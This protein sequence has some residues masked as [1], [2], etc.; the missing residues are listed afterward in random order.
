MLHLTYW[1]AG[2]QFGP[3]VAQEDGW[4]NAGQVMRYFREKS[5]L[6]AKTFG[7]LYG[8]KIREDGKPICERWI[9]EMELENKVPID[10]TR[11][12]VIAQLLQ[13]PPALFGLA[14]YLRKSFL[15]QKTLFH[16]LH[17]ASTR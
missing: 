12:R 5:D 4:P 17:I 15:P 14:S 8:K 3:F 1:G 13:I 16:C 2:G 9:L 7:K 6:T 11:R 10:I